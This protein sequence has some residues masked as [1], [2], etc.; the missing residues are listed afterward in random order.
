MKDDISLFVANSYL[1]ILT[2]KAN[3][4]VLQSQNQ[5]TLDQIDRTAGIVDARRETC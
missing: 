2:N 4:E 3:L 1:E 5:V